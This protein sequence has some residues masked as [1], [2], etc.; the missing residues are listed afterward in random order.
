MTP[1][2]RRPPSSWFVT[3]SL[4]LS[5]ALSGCP[6]PVVVP[7][8]GGGGT[9]ATSL[10]Y[11]PTAGAID[12][13]AMPF[14]DDLY[15]EDG[16]VEIGELPGEAIG[17]SDYAE[18]ARLAFRDLDGFGATT[19]VYFPVDG[20]VD[21]SSLP[22]TASGS[23][24]EDASAFLVDVDS[25]SP[26]ATER[27]P[28]DARFDATRGLI[29]LRPW[30]GHP[31]HEG[32][33]Y[34]AVVT[35]RVRGGDGLPIG[36][37]ARFAAV[38]DATARPTDP[39]AAEAWDEVQSV[40][41]MLGVPREE[42]AGLSVF[43]VQS[44]ALGLEQARS[45][46]HAATPGAV[47]ID[48]VLTATGI[49]GL[50]GMP[51]IDLAGLDIEGGVQHSHIGWVIDGSFEAPNFLDETAMVHGRFGHAA[52][53]TL[54]VRRTERV[55]FTVTLPLGD[56]SSVRVVIFQHGL[57][58][59]R[60][61]LFAIADA[62]AAEGWAVAAIDIPYHGMRAGTDPSVLDTRHQF[63]TTPGP[64]LYGEVGGSAVYLSFVGAS[65]FAGDL[66]PFHP[67]YVRDVLRQ[68]VA[69]LM[70]LVHVLDDGDW[71]AVEALGGPTGI[72]FAA[73]PM[74][75]VG[76]SLGGIVGTTFVAA[77]PRIGAAVLNV[78]GGTLTALVAGSATFNGT[79]LPILAPRIGL[80]VDAIDYATLPPEFLPELAI[81][82]TLLDAGDS[83]A[84]APLLA[85]EDR[86][87]LFQMALDDEVVPNRS[88][89][90]LARAAGASIAD[91]MPRFSD[92]TRETLPLVGNVRVG[93]AMFTRGLVVFEPATHGL[94]ST[95]DDE[96]R[97]VHPIEHPF[98]T[99]PAP[100]VV[101]NEVDAA[102]AQATR[103]FATWEV[104][105]AEIA[106]PL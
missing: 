79:F 75:F 87:L 17:F 86:H 27:V 56:V 52:D 39:L 33:T 99:L 89:E 2:R 7:A 97:Y 30:T 58:G 69:D 61:S 93:T 21:G 51:V 41:G 11:E 65:E 43:T 76:V 82:Q 36:A 13:G 6:D 28:V 94:L 66:S 34:A 74:G 40:I 91:A 12:F 24:L 31:L 9:S 15:L 92:L 102:V 49:D 77:E 62:L 80:D 14:P 44:I 100:V 98:E 54:E 26:A 4:F 5:A 81:Y 19:P 3:S 73:D 53:G 50:L 8:D 35:R 22:A 78:T 55:P 32:R 101:A 63:G 88:T 64:D 29:V 42:I 57:G 84:Y 83:M 37:S 18:T 23:T 105:T 85:L 67:F 70:G 95:R 48:R 45:V 10:V 25:A 103:F 106:A 20:T 72:G 1:S 46:I 104:G 59:E 96:H 68:S 16:H 90:G 47:T 38:R 71:S 60:S